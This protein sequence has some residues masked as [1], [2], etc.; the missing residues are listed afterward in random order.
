MWVDSIEAARKD[1]YFL[2][3]K[4]GGRTLMWLG[5]KRG[6]LV[7]WTTQKWVQATGRIVDL[8]QTPWLSGP[9]GTTRGIGVDFFDKWASEKQWIVTRCNQRLLPS[10]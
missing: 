3:K 5:D 7:D 8:A 10:V 4:C 2:T 6:N 1:S 9:I